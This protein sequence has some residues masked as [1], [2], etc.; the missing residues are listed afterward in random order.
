MLKIQ[1]VLRKRYATVVAPCV[2]ADPGAFPADQFTYDALVWAYSVFWSRCFG[3]RLRRGGRIVVVPSMVPLVDVLNHNPDADVTYQTVQAEV[4]VASAGGNNAGDGRDGGGET[5]DI[6]DSD[7]AQISGDEAGE[8]GSF[9]VSMN[10]AVVAGDEVFNNYGS[11]KDN[12]QLMLCYGFAIPDNPA[13][14]HILRVGVG[15][16]GHGDAAPKVAYGVDLCARLGL[17]S[18]FALTCDEG[19]PQDLILQVSFRLGYFV[20]VMPMA[21]IVGRFSVC[22]AFPLLL[23]LL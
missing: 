11:D 4:G 10:T 21:W 15:L 18:S 12:G 2:A 20:E 23:L 13:E 1:R 17:A 22:A 7:G 14:R 19:V 16:G 3:L 9:T 8:V 6:G 5:S